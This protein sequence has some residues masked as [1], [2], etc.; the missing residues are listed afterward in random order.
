MR[1][2][3]NRLAK[4]LSGWQH[5]WDYAITK[6]LRSSKHLFPQHVAVIALQF[7]WQTG[8]STMDRRQ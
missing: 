4:A 2:G 6:A 5:Y 7:S 3:V 8:C 1:V